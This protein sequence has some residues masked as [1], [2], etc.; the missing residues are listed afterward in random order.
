MPV[1]S[2]EII[3]LLCTLSEEEKLRVTLKE[4]LKGGLIAGGSAI[5]GGCLL[6]PIGLAFGG[7]LGGII[8][9]AASHNKF[10]PASQVIATMEQERRDYL[11]EKVRNIMQSIDVTD[12]AVFAAMVSGD[13]TI[14]SR[15]MDAL[16]GYLRNEMCL[17]FV[18]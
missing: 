16:I 8:A 3:E 14:R 7:A 5:L 18:E 4:S 11:A 13:I 15:V 1:N 6:G 10:L 9:A 2:R 12:I 17:A